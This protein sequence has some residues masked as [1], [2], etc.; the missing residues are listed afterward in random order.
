MVVENNKRHVTVAENQTPPP[1]PPPPMPPLSNYAMQLLK[2]T[3]KSMNTAVKR[4]RKNE[5]S[6]FPAEHPA[7]GEDLMKS[8][9]DLMGM[10]FSS[11]EVAN[12]SSLDALDAIPYDQL[13][14]SGSD[15]NLADYF[16][17]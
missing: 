10:L 11:N 3:K 5:K 9:T 6:D 7:T 14:M 4:K 1:P 12:H 8:S 2:M 16:I 13:F 17:N 15:M